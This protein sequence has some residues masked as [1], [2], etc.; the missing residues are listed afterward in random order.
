MVPKSPTCRS[1]TSVMRMASP[2]SIMMPSF[3][4]PPPSTATTMITGDRLSAVCYM[5]AANALHM[6]AYEFGRSAT[7]TLFTSDLTGFSRPSA[8]TFATGLVSPFSI[9]LLWTHRRVFESLGPRKSV[10][11]TTLVYSS[12]LLIATL[13]LQASPPRTLSQTTVLLLFVVKNGFVHLLMAQH[14][15]FLTSLLQSKVAS[16]TP[17]L[18][19]MASVTSTLAGWA[20]SPVVELLSSSSPSPAKGTNAGLIGLLV[21]ASVGVFSTAF[22]SDAAYAIAEKVSLRLRKLN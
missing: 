2:S 16:W 10:A 14:W 17:I 18:A 6:A 8:I 13:V 4:T 3:P 19:G 21:L 15:S 20:V 9:G 22:L 1:P 5:T 11:V 12:L 7:M